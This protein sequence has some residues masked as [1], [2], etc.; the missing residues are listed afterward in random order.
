MDRQAVHVLAEK[1]L[2]R[3]Y[4]RKV[5]SV[6]W[7]EE[8]F[9]DF[10]RAGLVMDGGKSFVRACG[11]DAF[12][13]PLPLLR[14][15]NRIDDADV[16]GSALYSKWRYLTHVTMGDTG[17]AWENALWFVIVLLRLSQLTAGKDDFRPRLRRHRVRKI[18][19]V[20]RA[21]GPHRQEPEDKAKERLILW[22]DGWVQ[23][24][25]YHFARKGNR[26]KKQSEAVFRLKAEDARVIFQWFTLLAR[27]DSFWKKS[28]IR[29][30][31]GNSWDLR[32]W[33]RNGTSDRYEGCDAV[34]IGPLDLSGI[35]RTRLHMPDAWMF[36]EKDGT[37]EIVRITMEC[38]RERG[39]GP[40]SFLDR[41]DRQRECFVLDG[42]SDDL[43]YWKETRGGRAMERCTLH[44]GV[45][46]FLA[47][48]D[49][50]QLFAAEE[51][52]LVT[53]LKKE[54]PAAGIGQYSYSLRVA[55]RGAPEQVLSGAFEA[56]ELPPDWDDFVK[57]VHAFY[58][59]HLI[60][61]T[62]L[63]PRRYLWRPRRPGEQIYCHVAFE[64]GGKTYCYRTEDESIRPGDRVLVPAGPEN[65]TKAVTVVRVEY[66]RPED[67]PYP[68]AKTKSILGKVR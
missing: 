15:I 35:L 20:S 13:E 19:L 33:S 26:D 45:A 17:H 23:R 60:C 16:L 67:A 58:R 61:G 11:A 29:V 38:I 22:E 27:G 49:G 50:H 59:E 68:P 24:T 54:K 65:E 21:G 36:D 8:A 7:D 66:V 14:R 4:S 2:S 64:A 1:H 3:F 57:K 56:D 32:M 43:V 47:S 34:R 31:D 44:G 40:F 46:R 39:E 25:I 48:F 9:R 37:R 62:V 42:A 51:N 6:N 18:Q 30:L 10:D 5:Y 52:Q 55:Y 12:L 63:D 53:I 41:M 28:M